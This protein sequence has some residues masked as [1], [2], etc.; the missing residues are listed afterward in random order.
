DEAEIARMMVGRDVLL[1]VDLHPPK[2][3]PVVLNVQN[4]TV[5]SDRGIPAV[6]G[7]SFELHQGEIL[8]IAGVEGNGQSEL[9]EV[10]AGTRHAASGKILLG[11][12]EIE[13]LGAAAIRVAGI[14]HIPEDRR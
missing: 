4:L 1:R 8:G 10:L 7:L 13:N 2:P 11:D 12:R 6:R 9:V 5:K 14:S 3:G